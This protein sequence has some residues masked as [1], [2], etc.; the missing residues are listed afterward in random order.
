MHLNGI[1]AVFKVILVADH[2][3][4]KLAHFSN[5]NKSLSQGIGQGPS[6]NKAPGLY[7]DDDVKED[8]P[9]DIALGQIVNHQPEA[10]RIFE[11]GGDIPEHDAFLGMIR[12]GS[13][14]RFNRHQFILL[15]E[16]EKC[17]ILARSRK[18]KISTAGYMNISRIEI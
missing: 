15:L 3:G 17:S 16:F 11:K 7:P 4:R 12:D 14:F 6:D 13:D 10:D 1:G 8:I 18:A 5:R 2:F 9:F